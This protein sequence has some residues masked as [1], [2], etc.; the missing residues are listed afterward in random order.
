MGKSKR[1]SLGRGLSA[2]IPPKPATPEGLEEAVESTVG[3]IRL[4]IEDVVPSDAQPRQS[5]EDTALEELAAS[6]KRHGILQPIVVRKNGAQ[7]EIIAGERRWRASQRAGLQDIPCVVTDIAEDDTLTVALVENVQREDLNA[8]EEAEAY[9]R[10]HDVMGFSQAEIA[11]AVGK[12][13][14]TISNAMRLLKLPG[15]VRQMVLDNELSMGHARALL[16]LEDGSDIERMSREASAK[17]WSVRQ[18][19]KAVRT[20]KQPAPKK[21]EGKASKETQDVRLRLQRALG[22]KVDVKLSSTGNGTM[23][24]HFGSRDELNSIIERIGA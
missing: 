5:F 9:K 24:V 10:L 19:E 7:Y 20:Q 8:I 13:R 22:A 14:A 23:V 11:E 1:Q 16:S 21:S 2:L 4:P 17:N 6:I 15:K 18:T 12:D 3:L